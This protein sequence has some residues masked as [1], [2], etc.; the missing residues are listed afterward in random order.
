V[1][2]KITLRLTC[3]AKK[4]AAQHR[5]AY[6]GQVK[7]I[8]LTI[9]PGIKLL[10]QESILNK[11]LSRRLGVINAETS[12]STSPPQKNLQDGVAV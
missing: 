3:R 12:D 4:L 5:R 1:L 7:P 11:T 6:R 9:F 8:V 10:P 2:I